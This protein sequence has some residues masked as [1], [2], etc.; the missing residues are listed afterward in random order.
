MQSFVALR[1]VLRNPD[2][3]GFLDPGELI[4]RRRRRRIQWLFG[5]RLTGPKLEKYEETKQTRANV[6]WQ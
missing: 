4:T 1:C 5:T 2:L 3:W 6:I